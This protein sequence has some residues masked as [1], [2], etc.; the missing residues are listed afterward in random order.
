M[1]KQRISEILKIENNPDTVYVDID[2]E[3]IEPV[4]EALG[5]DIEEILEY[6]NEM[7]VEDLGLI[8]GC[9]EYI[10]GRFMTDDVYDALGELERKVKIHETK[11]I[12]G[13]AH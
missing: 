13:G 12:Y 5:D 8:S 6:L 10:Y 2:S 9:F 7:P 1:N 3:F 11:D 4:L